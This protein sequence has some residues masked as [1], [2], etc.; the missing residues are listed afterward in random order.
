MLPRADRADPVQWPVL[1][2]PRPQ[3]DYVYCHQQYGVFTSP[4]SLSPPPFPLPAPNSSLESTQTA[5]PAFQKWLYLALIPTAPRFDDPLLDGLSLKSPKSLEIVKR[6]AISYCLN[7]NTISTWSEVEERLLYLIKVLLKYRVRFCDEESPTF[8]YKYGY[9]KWHKNS[10]EALKAAQQ[11]HLAFRVLMGYVSFSMV[12]RDNTYRV[13]DPKGDNYRRWWEIDL[14]RRNVPH[15]IIDLVHNS[16]LNCFNANY[17]RAGV[18]VFHD[19][20]FTHFI[21]D[22]VKWDVPLWIYWGPFNGPWRLPGTHYQFPRPS[23]DNIENGRKIVLQNSSRNLEPPRI[24]EGSGQQRNERGLAYLKRRAREIAEFVKKADERER[25][26]FYSKAAAQATHPLPTFPGPRVWTWRHNKDG[27]DE[28]I[29]TTRSEAIQIFHQFEESQRRYDPQRDEWDIFYESIPSS[30]LH[31]SDA[32]NSKFSS[33][34][35]SLFTNE[36]D[37]RDDTFDFEMRQPSPDMPDIDAQ[38]DGLEDIPEPQAPIDTQDSE[39]VGP[40]APVNAQASSEQTSFNLGQ[41]KDQDGEITWKQPTVPQSNT[42]SDEHRPHSFVDTIAIPEWSYSRALEDQLYSR[43]GFSPLDHESPCSDDAL[44]WDKVCKTLGD[45]VHQVKDK[46]Q[47][48]IRTFVSHFIQNHANVEILRQLRT[49]DI[50]AG[51]DFPLENASS[52]QARLLSHNGLQLYVITSQQPSD[53]QT[54]WV[55]TLDDPAAV[56]QSFRTPLDGSLRNAARLLLHNGIPFNTFS[57][58][59]QTSDSCTS[60]G[61]VAYAVH[62]LTHR[63][64][65]HKPDTLDYSRYEEIRDRVLSRPYKRAALLEGG[66]VWRIAIHSLQFPTDSELLVTQGPSEDAFSRGRAIELDGRRLFDDTL[67][68]DEKDLICGVYELETG[69]LPFLRLINLLTVL[70]RLW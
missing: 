24:W 49:S 33:S 65:Q 39:S 52:L 10:A 41:N 43:F 45:I 27:Y 57:P 13:I 32:L 67:R 5:A 30:I 42:L 64:L 15:N 3:E 56:L 50:S 26:I 28:R 60:H 53:S 29:P 44:K 37:S 21:N 25:A 62:K 34:S 63:P 38:T 59:P 7:E 14:G 68:D 2:R 69:T 11:S 35:P 66:I 1:S 12:A 31:Y 6:S 70:S 16:E 4:N 18:V 47:P 55:I 20:D 51:A 54:S 8:P 19:C 58:S 23:R 22:L 46:N 61:K 9:K 17:P 40:Q 48:C 36:L